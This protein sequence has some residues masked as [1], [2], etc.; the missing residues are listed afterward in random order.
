MSECN[1]KCIFPLYFGENG[2]IRRIRGKIIGSLSISFRDNRINK[3]TIEK[4]EGNNS[5]QEY[6]EAFLKTYYNNNIIKIKEKY[7]GNIKIN[8][9]YKNYCLLSEECNTIYLDLELLHKF[10]DDSFP[11]Y[12]LSFLSLLLYHIKKD[13]R[14]VMERLI[15]I[16]NSLNPSVKA[17][18]EKVLELKEVDWN[19]NLLIFLRNAPHSKGYERRRW[20]TWILSQVERD[21]PYDIRR[22]REILEEYGES[23]YTSECRTELY[24]V[25]K[26]TFD[27]SKERENIKYLVERARKKG[28]DI[29]YMRFGRASMVMG[30]VLAASKM[31]KI[32]EESKEKVNKLIDYLRKIGGEP[33]IIALMLK[34][35]LADGYVSE[36]KIIRIVR[37]IIDALEDIR[38]QK[39]ENTLKNG[40]SSDLINKMM[41][42]QEDILEIHRL[43]QE[44][45]ES[46]YQSS[47]KNGA[48]VF[49]GQRISRQG[50]SKIAYVNEVLKA[51]AGP[52]FGLEKYILEGGSEVYA[53]PSLEV[54]KY[55]DYWVEA[56]PLFI[57]EI[58]D[59]VYEIDYENMESAIRLMAPY[60]AENIRNAIN[61]N[62][63]R[64]T[65]IVVTTQSY[66]MTNM[67]KFWLE[68]EM[69]NYNLIKAYRLEEEVKEKVREYKKRIIECAEKIIS[70]QYM[71]SVV[72]QELERV[73][74][75]ERALLNII[76]KDEIFSREVAK[77]CLVEEFGLSEIVE[78]VKMEKNISSSEAREN[79]LKS[80]KIDEKFNLVRTNSEE[81]SLYSE[82]SKY[83]NKRL[84][85]GQSTARK[86]I[87]A[88]HGL[89]F[90]L[91]DYWYSATGK[92][93]AYNLVYA[94]SRVDLG[95]HE[96]DSVIALGQQLGPF[97][98]EAGIYAKELYEKINISKE[99]V[100]V[101]PNPSHA[102]GQ[103]T[104]ENASRDDNYSFANLIA[105][106]AEAM[107]ANAY[108]MIANI[109]YRPTHLILWPGRGYGGFCVPKDGL[110]VSY[111]LGLRDKDVLEKIDIP[112]YLHE[113]II[114]LSNKILENRFEYEDPLEWLEDSYESIKSLIGDRIKDFYLGSLPHIS[115]L[116]DKIGSP[117]DDWRSY[118]REASR[119]LYEERYLPARAVNIYMAYHA[120]MLIGHIT[121]LSAKFNGFTKSLD[122][123][124]VGI[125]ASYKPGVQ[126]SRLTTEFDVFLGLTHSIRRLK[127]LRW[128]WLQ[129]LV[130]KG[131]NRYNVPREIRVIDPLIDR[132]LWLFDSEITLRRL[133]DEVK[134]TLFEN[135]DG[136]S[137]DDIRFNIESYGNN[138]LDW[139][140]GTRPD[141]SLITIKEK[142]KVVVEL[143]RDELKEYGLSDYE[144]DNN[145]AKHG[146]EFDK[147]VK[148]GDIRNISE[149][150]LEKV[151]GKV[152]WLITYYKGFWD[153]VISGVRGLDILSLGIPHPNIV[154]LAYDLS[155]LYFLMRDGNPTSLLGV[156][157]GTAGARGPVWD[158]DLVKTWLA[159]GGVYTGIG[160]SD[161]VVERWRD[162]MLYEKKLAE[163][164]LINIM[165]ENVKEARKVLSEITKYYASEGVEKY[166]RLYS[167]D[168]LGNDAKTYS[169]YKKRYELL[170]EC[171]E[172]V[173][174]GID[175]G[176]LDFGTFLLIGGR[177]VIA[178][179]A[180]KVSSYEEFKDYVYTLRE[181]FEEKVRR[182]QSDSK[183]N[184]VRIFSKEKVDEIIKVFLIKE[185]KLLKIERVLGG[186]L[187]GEMRE[188][189]EIMQLRMIRKRQHRSTIIST[190]LERKKY[191]PDFDKNYL[192]AK[193]IL[194]E[195]ID[196]FSDEV[197][198]EYLVVLSYAFRSLTAEIAGEKA[199]DEIFEYISDYVLKIGGLTISEHKKLVDHLSQLAFLV[200]GKKD[201]LERIA[202]AAELLDSALAIELI[203]N[204][205]SWKERWTAIATFFDK[206]LNNHIF[207]YAPYLY[208]RATFSKDKE[209]NDVFTRKELFELIAR[210]HKW[211]YEYIKRNLTEKTELKLWDKKDVEILLTLGTDKDDV[212]ERNGY[213]EASKFVFKYARLRDLAT[214]Y[215]DGFYIPEILDE[216]DPNAIKGFDRVNVVI[217]YNLGNTTAMTFLS[218]GPYHHKGHGP[219]KNIIMTNFLKKA[220]DPR[221]GRDIALVEY[222]LMY[223]TKDEYV[224]AGGKNKILNFIVDPEL[225]KKYQ[226]IGPEGRFVLL[227]FKK[228]IVAHFVFPHFTHPWFIQQT[229]E[230]MGVPL[231]QS[232]IIDRLT[233]M[234]TILPEMIEYYNSHVSEKEKIPFMD[235]VNIYRRALKGL[236]LEERISKV[237]EIL[238]EFSKLRPKVIIKTST[239]SGGRG[240]IVA[241]LRKVDGT[242]ND[243]RIRAIDGSV[244]VYNFDDAVQF[245][246]RDIL[247]KD[248]AVIQEFIESKPREILTEEAFK[249]VIK[250]FESLGIEITRETPLYWN[251]R[252]YV[253][254]VPGKEP[255]IV[256][257]IMLIHVKSIANFGQGGQLFI[258]ERDM[259]KEEYRYLFD[260]MMKVSKATMKMM[261]MYG[262]ILAKRLGIR[263]RK[264]ALGIPYYVPMT[265]LSDLMLKPV[266]KDN[267]ITGWIVVPIE[268]NIGMGLFYPYEKQLE[269]KGRRGESV[270]PILRN[271]AVVGK[272]YK[273]LLENEQYNN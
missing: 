158:F 232:R 30:Y 31:Y 254:Q 256:G 224:K 166:Y 85:L 260:E 157:D 99:G 41:M 10:R 64:P 268:E 60:W 148:I 194:E 257:W 53:T 144:I 39:V 92:N 45:R 182:L 273:K 91:K 108:S 44:F 37:R 164:L 121:E 61:E 141:G 14:Y 233:Y 79:V 83:L 38:R 248:D 43:L 180:R 149:I 179:N 17:K 8:L 126:D 225:R 188:E 156:V 214:L 67:V 216:V 226:D 118:L 11:I 152:S 241:L 52:S 200:Q 171:L 1:R 217:M 124:S 173:I 209:F 201:K 191:T 63:K 242:L 76:A 222:G 189:W 235:Q 183:S 27:E 223:L 119:K 34:S 87:I 66:N 229:L 187:K 198:S 117:R 103:K 227:K 161:D 135:I 147:W 58:G 206:T 50:A 110:F 3:Y 26:N 197:F 243:E 51:F 28:V 122:K 105:L 7:N 204:A 192:H 68:E 211:L 35:L 167:G 57:H 168:E 253:T 267:K 184:S 240:T 20:I 112:A 107:D 130:E 181:K 62:R 40:N 29:V 15:D 258:L 151:R 131:I 36:A 195:N 94:P 230:E 163:M 100:Y 170:I 218:R 155:R 220:K 231:N 250:R 252:N 270:D 177:F 202:M 72:R 80:Y 21:Y 127:R 25:L 272:E 246:V 56:L 6:L 271:F 2:K 193:K 77:L 261:E 207:D 169:D 146:L 84:I 136:F 199:A 203:S 81:D 65:F 210:R 19:D 89:Q 12:M 178:S 113:R 5:L 78:K 123:C 95:P 172:K 212:A 75:R 190:L 104:L 213:L 142:P 264:N 22:I 106:T 74:D 186:A 159:Y 47:Y 114:E 137:E 265:N 111:V 153:D 263:V 262:P 109:N 236:S 255:E 249:Q 97:D 23:K 125:Q 140:I 13:V 69:A 96:I 221:S 71:E 150:L 48:Y 102:E 93:K 70:E 247:P 269:N 24:K 174:N 115:I 219:D 175:I 32:T 86:E 54:L 239:E 129:E 139:I 208:T 73:S 237:R 90:K 42:F 234:K 143:I 244:E 165:D 59:G 120:A 205:T 266:Y 162:E 101:Y 138:I 134:Y 160:I 4:F 128:R 46:L 228:P 215:H 251:F 185:E 132:D 259:F 196:F 49:F 82:V 245:I 145:F 9:V 176:N 33:Y 154:Q 116:L 238:L 16:Y 133:A 55:V 88:K 18:V 98:K